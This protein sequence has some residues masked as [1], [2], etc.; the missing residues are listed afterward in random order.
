MGRGKH[1]S[2]EKRQLIR[3]LIKDGKTYKEVQKIIGCSAKM[4]RNAIKF[5]EKPEKRGRKRV[6]NETSTRQIVR[7]SKKEPFVSAV[8]IKKELR[9]TPSVETIRRRLRE[10]NLYARS[11]RKVPLLKKIHVIK[12]LK[13]AKERVNWTDE[14]KVVLFGG[15]GS[16][17]FVRREPNT[18]QNPKLTLKTVKHGGSSIMIWGCFSY[19][20]VGPIHRIVGKMDQNVYVDILENVMWPYAEYE[21]PLKW[22]FQQDNDPKHTSK[23]AKAWF[24]GKKISVMEW[25]AQS[26][27][28]NP[29]EHLWGDVKKI[30]FEKN[31]RNNNEL[32][33]IAQQAWHNISTD[34]C[35]NLV[36]YMDR[37][38]KAVIKN[39]GYSTKY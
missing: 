9:L 28:L 20:G 32:W 25:P 21:M 12:R 10:N 35:R 22:V 13:F 33:E 3:N 30:I 18:E 11:P 24:A 16:R 4:I 36:D 37:R 38:C 14:S 23:K 6:L 34:R 39:N 2:N 31:P 8:D 17:Q 1:C 15:K 29:I 7:F 19:Y 26:P 5:V 27:D